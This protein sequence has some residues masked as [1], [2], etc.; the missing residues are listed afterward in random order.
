MIGGFEMCMERRDRIGRNLRS[1]SKVRARLVYMVMAVR[2]LFA[3][4]FIL[5]GWVV[6]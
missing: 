2:T 4:A 6:R 5:C 1:C 3:G